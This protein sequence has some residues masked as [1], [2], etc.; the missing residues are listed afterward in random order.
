MKRLSRDYSI[1]VTATEAKE[2]VQPSA[3]DHTA[4]EANSVKRIVNGQLVI[5][6][7]GKMFNALGAEL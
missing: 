2:G 3:L 7:D 4:A 1:T 5:I 6:R